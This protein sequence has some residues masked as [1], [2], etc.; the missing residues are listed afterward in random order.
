MRVLS[1]SLL[2]ISTKI[3][4]TFKA[5]IEFLVLEGCMR[6]KI[7]SLMKAIQGSNYKHVN[8]KSLPVDF[9]MLKDMEEAKYV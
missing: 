7:H 2:V 4:I 3:T 6:I 8:K 9:D 1:N 5:V